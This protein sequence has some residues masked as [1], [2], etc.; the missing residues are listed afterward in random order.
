[1]QNPEQQIDPGNMKFLH[2]FMTELLLVGNP[3]KMEKSWIKQKSNS[4]CL[5]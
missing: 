5:D 1:M 4:G 3:K 2:H